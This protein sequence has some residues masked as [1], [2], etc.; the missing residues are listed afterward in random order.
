MPNTI[1][2][3]GQKGGAGKTT[4]AI[5][6]A[7]E[8]YRRGHSVLLVDL[9][10]QGTATTWGDVASESEIDGPTV[11][12]MGD[13]V[14]TQLP[15]VAE[16]YDFV[17][18][19]CPPR[20]GKR[21]IGALMVSDLALLPCGPSPADL[22]ALTESLDILSQAQELR[23]ELQARI[24]MNGV[25]AS[26][27]L[28]ADVVDA[29]ADVH[30]DVMEAVVHSRVAMARTL[31]IGQGVTASEPNSQAADE[32]QACVNEVERVLRKH[33]ASVPKRKRKK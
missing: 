8:W 2:L 25:I 31:A 24:V 11:V 21:T 26:S 18:I 20:A 14:R 32:V 27:T 19:D 5:S 3:C 4:L 1:A 23:P 28:G 22:W 12:G 13:A 6:L 30:V 15:R 10:P 7:S 16:V 9:D 17:V 29:L 33:G